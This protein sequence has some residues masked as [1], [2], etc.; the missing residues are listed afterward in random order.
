MRISPTIG[1][2]MYMLDSM[3]PSL[4]KVIGVDLSTFKLAVCEEKKSMMVPQEYVLCCPLWCLIVPLLYCHAMY[5]TSNQRLIYCLH[6][7]LNDA[8]TI[9][10]IFNYSR[11]L[12]VASTACS[13]AP[14]SPAGC[15]APLRIW[16]RSAWWHTSRPSGCPRPS[17]PR[18]TAS[19][20]QAGPSPC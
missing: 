8:T 3:W 4:E 6:I 16:H 9:P 11:S 13:T 14:Q 20:S 10:F 17:S 5:Y 19:S 18:H 15:P 7:S 1:L 2:S 12:R